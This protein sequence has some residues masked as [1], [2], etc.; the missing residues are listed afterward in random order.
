VEVRFNSSCTSNNWKE[1]STCDGLHP[2]SEVEFIATIKV[3]IVF[4]FSLACE[5]RLELFNSGLNLSFE[6][7]VNA[8]FN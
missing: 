3:S 7:N 8:S 1:T 4:N 6:I 2:G 5:L